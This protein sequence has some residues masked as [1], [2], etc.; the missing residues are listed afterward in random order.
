ME[1]KKDDFT[2]EEDKWLTKNKFGRLEPL[3]E[4]CK[5]ETCACAAD[6]CLMDEHFFRELNFYN[7]YKKKMREVQRKKNT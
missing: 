1:N 6:E 7:A 4:Q 5:G 2:R 3:D